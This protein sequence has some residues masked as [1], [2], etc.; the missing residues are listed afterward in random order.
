M[1]TVKNG[2]GSSPRRINISKYDANYDSINW[3]SKR[4]QGIIKEKL[5]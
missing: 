1:K 3:K 4:K 5:K 2:K